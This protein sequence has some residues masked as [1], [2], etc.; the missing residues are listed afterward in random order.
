MSTI[1]ILLIPRDQPNLLSHVTVRRELTSFPFR[2]LALERSHQWALN[3]QS[4]FVTLSPIIS[5]TTQGPRHSVQPYGALPCYYHAQ[6]LQSGS[7]EPRFSVPLFW[8][9][10]ANSVTEVDCNTS[11]HLPSMDSLFLASSDISAMATG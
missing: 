8:T 6:L 7:T 4:G 2:G 10:R 1:N 9:T 5:D 3:T 11:D